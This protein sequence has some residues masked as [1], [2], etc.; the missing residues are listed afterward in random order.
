MQPGVGRLVED[1]FRREPAHLVSALVR[2]L[3]ASHLSL[4]EDGVQDALAD[5]ERRAGRSPEALALYEH[6]VA[7][8][9]SEAERAAYG[10][11]A[12]RLKT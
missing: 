11:M 9:E 3:G 4:A 1:L 12:A 2:L 7:R 10:K 8:A 6:A 5:V